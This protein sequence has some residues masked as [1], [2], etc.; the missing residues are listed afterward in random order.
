ML[1][2]DLYKLNWYLFVELIV[3][4]VALQDPCKARFELLCL[5]P[6]DRGPLE[7]YAVRANHGHSKPMPWPT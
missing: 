5:A 6:R 7:P 4:V 1:I 3:E 2:T